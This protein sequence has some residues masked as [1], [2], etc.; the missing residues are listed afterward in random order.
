MQ[1]EAARGSKRFAKTVARMIRIGTAI[2][3]AVLA[4]GAPWAAHTTLAE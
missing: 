3:L 1:E 4:S 2:L